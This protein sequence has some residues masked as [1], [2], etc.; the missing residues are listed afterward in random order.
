MNP[1]QPI[2][3]R[4]PEISVTTPVGQA[5]E[6][7][8]LALFRPFD[9]GKWFVIGFCAWLA[10]LGQQ[11]GGGGNF[12][13]GS[14]Q[15]RGD[16]VMQELGRAKDYVMD[17][18]AWIVPVAVGFLVLVLA[19]GLLFN[20]LSSRGKF[21]FLHCVAL[22]KAEVVLPWNQFAREANSLFWFRLVLGLLGAIL[23]LPLVA[24]IVILVIGMVKVGE[25]NV[26]GVVV[27][28]G[29]LLIVIALGIVFLLIRKLTMDF[30]VP[31]MFL[32]RKKCLESWRELRGLFT[33]NVG[34][35][36]LYFL[37][38]IVLAIVIGM[39]V[40]VVVIATCC[41]AGCFMA[42]PYLG[43]VLLLPVHVFNR[44]YSLYYLA[45]FGP[46]FDVFPP[47]SAGTPGS[48]PPFPASGGMTSV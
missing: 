37:F 9:L 27:S 36:I 39:M 11:G 47:E 43:T 32:R 24:L 2:S 18:L 5:W 42:I 17:N 25:A 48:I 35:F 8:T 33:G 23:T 26:V 4:P 19:L 31:I 12:N 41:I 28:A 6:R 29:A 7:V 30:V 10:L 40:L 45:Q 15:G 14:H 44:A 13:F 20:W 16:S 34:N 21:M 22:N 46:E 3:S 38:K 1:I